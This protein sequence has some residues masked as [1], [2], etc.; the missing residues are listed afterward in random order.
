M[1][2]TVVML[3]PPGACTLRDDLGG[4]TEVVMGEVVATLKGLSL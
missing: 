4:G 1:G 2:S 3:M